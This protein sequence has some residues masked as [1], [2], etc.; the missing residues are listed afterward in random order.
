MIGASGVLV[1]ADGSRVPF[2]TGPREVVL[3]ERYA[4]ANGLPV[5][6]TEATLTSYA[7]NTWVL[8]HAYLGSTRGQADRPAFEEWL[9]GVADVAE[10]DSRSVPPTPPVASAGLSVPSL[11][12]PASLPNNFG[13]PT[14]AT[15]RPS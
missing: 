13:T 1:L 7:A 8:Y 9:E 2:E 5:T 11:P 12:E 10:F 14:P 4:N 15:S 6:P 3:W